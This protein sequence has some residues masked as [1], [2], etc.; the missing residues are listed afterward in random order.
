[1]YVFIQKTSW[2]SHL[3]FV[4]VRVMNAALGSDSTLFSLWCHER[5]HLSRRHYFDPTEP[6]KRPGHP[7]QTDVSCQLCVKLRGSKH[8][9]HTRHCVTEGLAVLRLRQIYLYSAVQQRG[10]SKCFT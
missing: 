4:W 9:R 5:W 3:C 10:D 6:I 2:A 1:M 8:T 7:H